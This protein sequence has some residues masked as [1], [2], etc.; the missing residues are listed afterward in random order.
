VKN[1]KN[2][3]IP[4]TTHLFDEEPGIIEKVAEVSTN[5]FQKM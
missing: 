5:G 2:Y 1:P 3:A 4:K